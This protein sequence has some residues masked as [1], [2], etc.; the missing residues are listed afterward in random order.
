MFGSKTQLL[1]KGKATSDVFILFSGHNDR[2]IITLCRYFAASEVQFAI[3]CS[4]EAD[5]IT[6]T[7][8]SVNCII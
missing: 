4:S 1:E 8:W 2:A 3:V 5:L 7:E 6:Q